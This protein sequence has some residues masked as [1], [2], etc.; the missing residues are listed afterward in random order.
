M[1]PC[2]VC[3]LYLCGKV[4]IYLRNDKGNGE[5]FFEGGGSREM[6]NDRLYPINHVSKSQNLKISK[7]QN[8][9][10]E[11]GQ[12]LDYSFNIIIIYIYYNNIT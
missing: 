8:G 2:I 3:V 4:T 7:S 11:N 10:I 12:L 5:N 6:L 9:F 1:F